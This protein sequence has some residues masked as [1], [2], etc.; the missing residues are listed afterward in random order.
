M[1]QEPPAQALARQE[2]AE[3]D[4]AAA[5]KDYAKWR[6]ELKKKQAAVDE[7]ESAQREQAQ[8]ACSQHD[9]IIA[10]MEAERDEAVASVATARQRQQDLDRSLSELRGRI[11]HGE[12]EQSSWES[13]EAARQREECE[14][15]L[16]ELRKLQALAGP[17]ASAAP[18]ALQHSDPVANPDV[19][20][21]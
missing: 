1:A 13:D 16:Q 17:A 4:V 6:H 15:P 18:A 9:Q 3:A 19:G 14:Q 21:T 2:E 11:A 20:P 7:Q 10:Q 8:Q 12:R 5:L